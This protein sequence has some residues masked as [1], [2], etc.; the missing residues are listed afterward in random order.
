[1]LIFF[2]NTIHKIDL[3]FKITTRY[4][5]QYTTRTNLLFYFIIWA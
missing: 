1:L 4:E 5:K 3:L 2:I